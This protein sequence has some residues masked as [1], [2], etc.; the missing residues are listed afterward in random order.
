M[1]PVMKH[2]LSF[3][4]IL[5]LI[6]PLLALEQHYRV[7]APQIDSDGR[8]TAEDMFVAGAPGAPAIPVY[9]VRILLPAGTSAERVTIDYGERVVLGTVLLQPVQ[10]QYPF[11]QSDQATLTE[12][13]TAVWAQSHDLP[14]GEIDHISN[15]FL[16]GYSILFAEAHP[17][18]YNPATGELGYYRDFT[19]HVTTTV[20]DC[21]FEP[22]ASVRSRVLELVDNPEAIAPAEET[23]S[24]T[25]A[26]DYIIVTSTELESEFQLLANWHNS[27]GRRTEILL[28]EDILAN[29]EG[30]DSA[31]QL[32]NCLV[33]E[34]QE[35]GFQFL[36]L[37]GD[38]DQ[39]PYRELYV[40]NGSYEDELPSDLYFA[41]L[42]GTW[43]NDGDPFW[44][45]HGEEDWLSEVAVGRASV[46]NSSE[47]ANFV[48]KQ[49]GYQQTPV[50]GELSSYLM[51]GEQLDSNPTWGGDCKDEIITGC[52][53]HGI[54]THGLPDN[55]DVITL[56][57]RQST[58][59]PDQ[60]FTQLGQGVN[61][62]NHLGHCNWN[63]MMKFS[64]G[65]V[66]NN[67]LTANGI[68]HSYHIGYSQGCIPGAFENNDCII[69]LVTNLPTGY[70]AFI[71]NSRYGWYQPG[72]TGG[73][74]QMFDREFFDALFGETIS[75]I[76]F[77]LQDSK[78]DLVSQA[79]NDDFMRWVYYELILFGD[80]AMHIWSQEPQEVAVTCSDS[81]L[82][83]ST[84]LELQVT[85]DQLPT[86]GL[87]TAVTRDGVVYG[88]TVTDSDGQARIEFD[89]AL[90]AT[91]QYQLVV[92][93]WNCLAT[94]F[95]LTVTPTS[96]AFLTLAGCTITDDDGNGNGMPEAGEELE[97]TITL[98]N[99]GSV[100]ATGVNALLSCNSDY[101]E[102]SLGAVTLDDIEP[103][104]EMTATVPFQLSI[105]NSTPDMTMVDCGFTIWC[106]DGAWTA[107]LPLTLH[108]SQPEITDLTVD[109]GN[110]G[111][112]DPG[113]TA[114]LEL[115][116]ENFGSGEADDLT[117]LLTSTDEGVTI[118]IADGTL[119]ELPP[120]SQAQLTFQVSV[121]AAV[122]PGHG[123][124]FDLAL[125]A[126]PGLDIT[127]DFVLVVGEQFEGFET[128]DFSANDWTFEGN[129]DWIIDSYEPFEGDFC[130]RSGSIDHNQSSTITL[131]QYAIME[132][133][134]SF[135]C[136][137]S[138]Q[139][140]QDLLR[141]SIDG[142]EQM[143]LSGSTGWVEGSFSVSAG[144]HSYSWSY[145][146]NVTI[147][148]GE[149]CVW[150]DA[151]ALPPRGDAQPPVI[152]LES[153]VIAVN[154]PNGGETDYA[155][156]IGNSGDMP[157]QY[158]LQFSESPLRDFSDDM[159]S[160]ENDWTSS[161]P[162]H[163]SAHRSHSA[164]H[165]WYAGV[166]GD[167]EYEDNSYSR[168]V[169][170]QFFAP[171]DA[172]LS[173]WHWGALE[174][175][176]YDAHDA[177]LVQV[178]VNSGDWQ[179]AEPL[180]GYSYCIGEGVDSPL[181]QDTPCFSGFF[182]WQQEHFNLGDW[183]GNNIRISFL[184]ASDPTVHYE[185]WYLD[186]VQVSSSAPEW[187]S[188]QPGAGTVPGNEEVTIYFHFDG[189]EYEE[190][191][192]T[193]TLTV[194]SND[195]ENPEVLIPVEFMV[196]LEGVD[197]V[198]PLTFE[199]SQNYPNP[200]NPT[201]R[202]AFNLPQSGEVRLDVY[203][204][205][206][207]HIRQLL[208]G[209]QPAGEQEVV[210][211]AADL[212]AGVYFYRLETEQFSATRKMLLVK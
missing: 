147:S 203:D 75:Q 93:G 42:D 128:G 13:D 146:K 38:I 174:A 122:E 135:R 4:L 185:G 138:T 204:L 196:S 87:L 9:P 61:V 17:V 31:E 74:S 171:N 170:P 177:V 60:L 26:C 210:F 27:L 46:S 120:G 202:I 156:Q 181:P 115:T 77:T 162:W 180:D 212:S 55:I 6:T 183:A 5:L 89:P 129:A 112:L 126:D 59:S 86:A 209:I 63:Y 169:S 3:L 106:D 150:I 8:I 195:I 139:Q 36:L 101:V 164:D 51:I 107:G 194:Q 72:G 166:E 206:G 39:L 45:E 49:L 154:A 127:L 114:W 34:Y 201:T 90:L 20:S 69:E 80:P 184:F 12:R 76:G 35:T 199:L 52:N 118:D 47:A 141:F 186:D 157:L 109:D 78:E 95:P 163:L 70:A 84:E 92:S 160:G 33:T 133:D 148:H 200:F 145:I 178:S 64:N 32:R 165:A 83:G 65:D 67:N 113:E 96:G 193:G 116:L 85:L 131:E 189:S 41:A 142:E 143:Q 110:D 108:A 105:A 14:P 97:L 104:E 81:L 124:E 140:Y 137:T 176:E 57:D 7:A 82:V 43:N 211:N 187:I 119:P 68:S 130:A 121:D 192:L 16:G 161:D 134:I 62:S 188:Y 159:E 100:A 88:S 99:A 172:V 98:V 91:G 191:V 205:K 15:Q 18:R 24:R 175:E 208:T 207:R 19:V 136:R 71:G 79:I 102:V 153:A 190:I 48:N 111:S 44:G 28:I 182:D 40:D 179:L 123:V 198:E 132:G 54:N 29:Y 167:W 25:D 11:S 2:Q 125:N 10:R 144:W 66:T 103:G 168:L 58:W 158:L 50:T 56:Y 149:D 37:A 151:I 22:A 173:F 197:E 94:Q 1:E 155:L 30:T 53:L 73:S 152:E 23:T 21:R 117:A